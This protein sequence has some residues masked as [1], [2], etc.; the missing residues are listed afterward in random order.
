MI[1][2]ITI[3]VLIVVSV[4]CLLYAFF[5]STAASKSL[6]EAQKNLVLAIEARKVADDQSRLAEETTLALRNVEAELKKC[7]ASK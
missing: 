4:I 5:Q 7:K 6:L 1:K 3:A 2:N